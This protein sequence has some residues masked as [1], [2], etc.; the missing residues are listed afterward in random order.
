MQ[1]AN[2]A[3]ALRNA[4]STPVMSRMCTEPD[5][6]LF[7]TLLSRVGDKWSLIV[8]GI[9]SERPFRFTELAELIPGISRR[10]LTVTLRALE[11][12][13][14]VQ[15][16]AYAEIPPRVV[17]QL[18]ELGLSMRDVVLQLA[19]WVRLHQDEIDGNR[20]RFDRDRGPEG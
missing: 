3:D 10:M 14:L 18:S 4:L 5:A 17:Y 6:D 1:E 12:D 9:L 2:H 20:R 7:R 8:I 16:T 15:R 13:G 11:R 19:D